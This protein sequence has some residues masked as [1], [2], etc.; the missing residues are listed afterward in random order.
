MQGGVSPGQRKQCGAGE[1]F[2]GQL[3]QEEEEEGEGSGFGVLQCA[4]LQP[5]QCETL[6]DSQHSLMGSV[7][8]TGGFIVVISMSLPWHYST[9]LC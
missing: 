6:R 5:W 8:L 7:L 9:W 2:L 1:L 3:G 4:T